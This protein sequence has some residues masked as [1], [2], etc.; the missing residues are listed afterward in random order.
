MD[1]AQLARICQQVERQFPE[2]R[3]C[4]PRVQPQSNGT[5]LIFQA[6]AITANGKALQRIIR[7]SVNAAGKITKITTSR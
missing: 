6:K 1:A 7:V 2:A 4:R 3:G 5:A